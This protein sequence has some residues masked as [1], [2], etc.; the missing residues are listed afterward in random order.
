MAKPSKPR[1]PPPG[2]VGPWQGARPQRAE[3]ITGA[4]L[5]LAGLG[6]EGLLLAARNANPSRRGATGLQ[7]GVAH[8]GRRRGAKAAGHGT[9]SQAGRARALAAGAEPR[10]CPATADPRINVRH[11]ERRRRSLR[12]RRAWWR[13][14]SSGHEIPSPGDQH[15]AAFLRDDDS[16]PAS[17]APSSPSPMPPTP[18]SL[19]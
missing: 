18:R 1:W 2:K 13:S 12:R 7:Q 19:Q 9:R 3:A 11:R 6:F 8:E 4:R 15:Q 14:S 10:V 17:S 5:G 16:A